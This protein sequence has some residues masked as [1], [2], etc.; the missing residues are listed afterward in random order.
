[1]VVITS[2]VEC[3]THF[4]VDVRKKNTQRSRFDITDIMAI[5]WAL[6]TSVESPLSFFSDARPL[7][8]EI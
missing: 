1:M 7:R 8:N 5:S 2:K 6:A 3:F 4:L